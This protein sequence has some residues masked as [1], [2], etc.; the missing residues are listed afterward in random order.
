MSSEFCGWVGSLSILHILSFLFE[1]GLK[2]LVVTK[3]RKWI[4][5]W[6]VCL[7]IQYNDES[8]G[9]LTLLGSQREKF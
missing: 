3:P 8:W 9:R 1:E 4:W 2:H 5:R 6:E 7:V